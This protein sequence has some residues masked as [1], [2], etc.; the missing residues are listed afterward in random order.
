[1]R[2]VA[3]EGEGVDLAV[4]KKAEDSDDLVVRLVETRGR[5]ATAKLSVPRGFGGAVP[6]AVPVLANELADTGAPL[7]LPVNLSFRPFE[8]KTFR[9]S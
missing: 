3:L 5:R 7:A 8:I 6:V 9:R 4:L 1:M 2:E